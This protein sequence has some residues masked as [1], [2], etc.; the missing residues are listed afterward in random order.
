[1]KRTV[2]LALLVALGGGALA[3]ITSDPNAGYVPSEPSRC[4]G[5]NLLTNLASS[6]PVL[7]G[8][9]LAAALTLEN[10]QALL[11]K[12]ER[13]GLSPSYLF[14]TVHLT[15]SRVREI[16]LKTR[17]AL[18]SA[19]AVLLETSDIS[20]ETT[21]AALVSAAR[22]AVYTDGRTL[23]RLLTKEE[24]RKVQETIDRAGVPA[25][26]ARIYRP[27]MISMM[28][29]ASNCERRRIREGEPVLDMALAQEARIHGIPITGLETA[30]EQI[31]TL[32]SVPEDQ[33]LG[34]LRANLALIDE[35]DNLMETMVQ[36]Y[37]ERRIGAVWELQMALAETAGVP[38]S[39]FDAFRQAVIVD[40]NIKMYETSRS[41]FETG[42]TFMAVGALHLPGEDGLVALL[43]N[44]GYTVTPVE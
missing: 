39:A 26:S 44:A 28:L 27:W 21:A 1:M 40:R 7:H 10:G 19:K 36:L 35:T 14:G 11:W 33:Q 38:P 5:V 22:T 34:M 23:D 9:I 37:L 20:P 16:S 18:R 13:E 4:G 25:A 43:R 12:V 15:D 30:E 31:R 2:L 41:Y 42:G 6:D 32:A 29:S 24:F 8:R 3:G 17:A